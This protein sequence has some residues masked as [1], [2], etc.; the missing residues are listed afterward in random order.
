MGEFLPRSIV[1]RAKSGGTMTNIMGYDIM[2]AG[3]R[4]K[5]RMK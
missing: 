5:D 1:G 2:R 4:G 3:E